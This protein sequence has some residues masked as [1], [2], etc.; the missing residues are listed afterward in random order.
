MNPGKYCE[1]CPR[2]ILCIARGEETLPLATCVIC[3]QVFELKKSGLSHHIP[4]CEQADPPGP[5]PARRT[6]C[7]RIWVY[8]NL[9]HQK[10]FTCKKC[11]KGHVQYDSQGVGGS[12]RSR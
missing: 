5:V 2:A 1:I 3:A 6:L 11:S 7:P 4:T 10:P 9:S 8:S 12:G